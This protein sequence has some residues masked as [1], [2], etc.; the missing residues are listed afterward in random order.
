MAIIFI[1]TKVNVL[2]EAASIRS[3]VQS[4]LGSWGKNYLMSRERL[5]LSTQ[6]KTSR[7]LISRPSQSLLMISK[8]RKL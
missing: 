2:R 3:V 6:F 1:T 8:R 5:D 4:L 7:R